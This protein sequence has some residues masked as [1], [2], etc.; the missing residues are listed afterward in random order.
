MKNSRE[1]KA[2]A[3][4]HHM[5]LGK[6]PY[7]DWTIILALFIVTALLWLSFG[8]ALWN[9]I[10]AESLNSSSVSSTLS[11]AATSHSLNMTDLEKVIADQEQKSATAAQ[12]KAKYVGPVD[13]SR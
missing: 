2:S 9:T 3:A 12:Y 7:F 13:P 6:D 5:R 1:A 11:T 8:Y 10:A 4:A